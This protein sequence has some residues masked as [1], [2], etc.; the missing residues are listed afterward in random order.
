M[1]R[2]V[3][4]FLIVAV[5]SASQSTR[6]EILHGLSWSSLE[7]RGA[8]TLDLDPIQR[9]VYPIKEQVEIPEHLRAT[10]DGD[11]RVQVNYKD[12]QYNMTVPLVPTF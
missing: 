7:P 8:I 1:I 11:Y 5:V 2:A 9:I 12:A 3:L 10:T 4:F 6:F